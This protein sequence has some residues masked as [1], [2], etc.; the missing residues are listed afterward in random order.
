MAH[1][2]ASF[3]ISSH[4]FLYHCLGIRSFNNWL[5]GTQEEYIRLATRARRLVSNAFRFAF[6]RGLAAQSAEFGLP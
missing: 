1:E 3:R 4:W 6:A 5:L 2:N